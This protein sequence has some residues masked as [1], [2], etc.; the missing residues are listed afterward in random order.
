MN[1]VLPMINA[2][3]IKLRT[4]RGLVLL[5][6]VLCAVSV[7]LVNGIITIYHVVDPIKNG[8][9]GGLHGFTNSLELFTI[10]GGLAAVLIGATAGAQDVSS[11]VFRSLV[12]TGQSRVKLALV[13]IPGG[14]MLLLPL[15]AVGYAVEVLA[16]FVLADGT[17]TPDAASLL[18]GAGWLLA[19]AVLNYTVTLGLAALLRSRGTAIGVM[20]AW[21]LAGSRAI[22]RIS[23][24]GSWRQLV[25]SFALDRFLPGATDTVQ[26]TRVDS[27]SV[28]LGAAVA[29]VIAWIV[30]AIAL[31]T[32][33]T[34]TQ[35]A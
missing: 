25:S 21:E 1:R 31:G 16:S 30:V 20:I 2:E 11:G 22:E 3:F 7:V 10:A 24:F 29:V 33:R 9:A 28:T 5:S 15:L 32:W 6:V 12:A 18:V 34:A 26:L 19:L 8:P 13:R 4:R 17:P 14:L 27:I 23:V 35:D